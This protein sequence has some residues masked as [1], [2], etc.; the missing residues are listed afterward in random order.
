[1]HLA[2]V[3]YTKPLY[4]C[5][6]FCKRMGPNCTQAEGFILGVRV[7]MFSGCSVRRAPC[8]QRKSWRLFMGLYD[9]DLVKGS[10]LLSILSVYRFYQILQSDSLQISRSPSAMD[11]KDNQTETVHQ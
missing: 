10:L 11:G 8:Q 6:Y 9:A 1:M 2:F 7:K 5:K 4:Q 3:H